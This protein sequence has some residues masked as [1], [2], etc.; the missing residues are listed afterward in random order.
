MNQSDFV[1]ELSA[2]EYQYSWSYEN[3]QLIGERIML[4][5]GKFNPITAVCYSNTGFKYPKTR[6]G[7][8]RAARKL[9][10]T[11]QLAEAIMST[12]N[13]GHAQIIRGKML[14]TVLG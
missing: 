14:R 11:S 3:G 2:I 7:T 5:H 12:S 9:G 13:R 10:I 1:K 6:L 4:P 8:I